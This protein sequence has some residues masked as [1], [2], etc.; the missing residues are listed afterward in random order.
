MLRDEKG[1]C[2]AESRVLAAPFPLR[3]D[4]LGPRRPRS[5]TSRHPPK[6]NLFRAPTCPC[7]PLPSSGGR[8]LRGGA[9]IHGTAGRTDPA[10]SRSV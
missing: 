10:S 7:F 9:R 2:Q 5:L 4:A 8:Y 1:E 3:V 6:I